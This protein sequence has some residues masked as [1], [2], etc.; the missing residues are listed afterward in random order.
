[1]QFPCKVLKGSL[2]PLLFSFSLSA[3]KINQGLRE[4]ENTVYIKDLN[5]T[6]SNCV[7]QLRN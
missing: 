2:F 1:M 3:A 4:Q 6:I 5:Y 7:A